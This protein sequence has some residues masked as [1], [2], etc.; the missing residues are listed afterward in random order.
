[1]KKS[2][3]AQKMGTISLLMIITSIMVASGFSFYDYIRERARLQDDFSEMIAPV[4]ARLASNLNAPIWFTNKNQAEQIIATE[5]TNKRIYAVIVRDAD[6]A[7]FTAKKRDDKWKIIE[8]DGKV[9]GNFI[10]KEDK[11]VYEE[12]PEPIGSV[13]VYFSTRF[14]EES[15]RNLIGFMAVRVVVMSVFIV[16]VLLGIVNFFFIKPISQVIRTLNVVGNEVGAAS[17]RLIAVG[18]Q[19]AGGASRQT[20]AVEETSSSLD[21]ITAAIR[22]NMG[23]VTHAN[24][25]MIETSQVVNNAEASMTHLT[26]S[27]DE[28]AKTSDETR[29]VIKDIEDIAFQINLLA[30]NAS[31]EAAHAGKAGLGFAV[32]AQEVRNLALRSKKAAE[33]TAALIESSIQKTGKGTEMVYKAGEAFANVSAGAK[34]VGELLAKVAGF[35]Q[36][37][38]QGIC[39]ISKAMNDINRVTQ[40]NTSGAEETAVAIQEIGL[41]AERMKTIVAELVTLV[42]RKGKKRFPES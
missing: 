12:E 41:Q 30:L 25:L 9:S 31:V 35:S 23:N 38:E 21:E 32:V 13:S 40:E 33:N 42:G 6:K 39:Y 26:G 34:K 18:R 1:M 37:Q 8:S 16:L 19:L 11:I 27:I 3:V 14:M 20:A 7:V 17:E 22:E 28:I 24:N 10:I 2:A 4:S 5:M 29:K 36:D 15:L